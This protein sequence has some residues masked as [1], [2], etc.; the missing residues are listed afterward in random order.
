MYKQIFRQFRLIAKCV[1]LPFVLAG[2]FIFMFKF[3]PTVIGEGVYFSIF[4][5]A[6]IFWALDTL[7]GTLNDARAIAK[8]IKEHR[9][10]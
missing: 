2:V 8:E 6:G 10:N 7:W 3:A 5:A 1:S 4:I 9:Q